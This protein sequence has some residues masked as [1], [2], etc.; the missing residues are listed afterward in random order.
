VVQ[1]SAAPEHRELASRADRAPGPGERGGS[2]WREIALD[3][4]FCRA[5][6]LDVGDVRC[7]LE[8]RIPAADDARRAGL[9]E[10]VDK[11]LG[12]GQT[13]KGARA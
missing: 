8:R 13:A 1:S 4:L 2:G 6:E 7:W 3:V 11:I 5:G 9:E 10:I 12:T